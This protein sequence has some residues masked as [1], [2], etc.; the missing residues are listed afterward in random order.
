VFNSFSR[1]K[2][3]KV[4]VI[5]TEKRPVPLEHYL[6]ANK[7]LYK[8]VDKEGN[9]L[10]E[11]YNKIYLL[12]RSL[13]YKCF[14]WSHCFSDQHKILTKIYWT[15]IR[16]LQLR[17]KRKKKPKK[18]K[19]RENNNAEVTQSLLSRLLQNKKMYSFFFVFSPFIRTHTHTHTQ[20]SDNNCSEFSVL[21]VFVFQRKNRNG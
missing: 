7:E 3:K 21:F 14:E 6:Y 4:F 9:F 13:C 17:L 11:G 12:S 10:S 18:P 15:V 19:W 2:K 20:I 8:I 16:P 1:V 5:K